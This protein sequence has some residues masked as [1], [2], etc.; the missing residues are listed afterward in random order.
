MS[1]IESTIWNEAS[2][3]QNRLYM[4]QFIRFIF[5]VPP[6]NQQLFTLINHSQ[7]K[8][9]CEVSEGFRLI[10]E[11]IQELH[12]DDD[13]EKIKQLKEEY[14]RLFVGPN[15]L[16][17]PLWESV[18]LSREHLLFDEVTL[19][20]RKCYRQY[21]LSFIRESNEPDDHIVIELEFLSYLI[22][23]TLDSDDV[24]TKKELLDD[25]YSFLTNHLLKWC[26]A[27]CELLS[28]ST[29]F[30]LYQGLALLLTEYL[31]FEI[32]LIPVL[33]EVLET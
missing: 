11:S 22:Q 17:A 23:K 18:Y 7:W 16:P 21:G 13:G 33:K 29:S 25:Q 15:A 14:N 3:L 19:E 4:N 1:T 12:T 32:E 6:E 28:N 10:D 5:D 2:L 31:N 27:L 9:L 8:S 20:V 30:E 24:A 26:P